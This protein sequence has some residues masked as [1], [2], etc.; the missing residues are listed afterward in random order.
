MPS[1]AVAGS[2]ASNTEKESCK[3]KAVYVYS[4]LQ[5]QLPMLFLSTV[6]LLNS[7]EVLSRDLA[8]T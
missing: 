5:L 3:I 4:L 2:F 7:V 6:E 8:K 1:V